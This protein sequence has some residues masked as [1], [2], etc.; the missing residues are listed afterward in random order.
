MLC[1]GFQGKQ[2][3][4]TAYLCRLAQNRKYR[5]GSFF[6]RFCVMFHVDA[7]DRV[8]L[9]HDMGIRTDQG[10]GNHRDY[11]FVRTDTAKCHGAGVWE[12]RDWLPQ[13]AG[14]FSMEPC[15]LASFL[16][17]YKTICV[18]KKF[19]LCMFLCPDIFVLCGY[20]QIRLGP[21]NSYLILSLIIFLKILPLDWA[22]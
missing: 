15:V 13:S 14:D 7:D 4:R 11:K 6:S 3:T 18:L 9:T 10:V 20:P 12:S 8:Y 17:P 21:Y 19:S 1:E 16:R 2:R 22:W 5:T